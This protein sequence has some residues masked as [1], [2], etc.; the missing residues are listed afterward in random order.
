MI[1]DRRL[2]DGTADSLLPQIKELAPR[3][4]IVIVTGY[5]DLDG[6]VALL[7]QGIAD[8][9]PKPI[10]PELLRA[11][12]VRIQ[13]LNAAEERVQRSERLAAMGQMMASVAHKAAMR[14][15]ESLRMLSSYAWTKPLQQCHRIT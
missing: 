6:A 9:I 8:F 11:S 15:S 4:A 7:R 2:P 13:A 12:L 10:N 3:A 1:L 14:C 5:G